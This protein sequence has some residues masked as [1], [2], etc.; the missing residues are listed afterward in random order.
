MTKKNVLLKLLVFCSAICMALCAFTFIPK[1]TLAATDLPSVSTIYM[2]EGAEVRLKSTDGEYKDVTG[3]RFTMLVNKDYY[4]ELTDSKLT[5][6]VDEATVKTEADMKDSAKASTSRFTYNCEKLVTHAAG[7]KAQEAVYSFNA[8]V[9]GLPS[10]NFGTKLIANGCIKVGNSEP[11]FATN[12]Q[13]RSISQV[14]SSALADNIADDEFGTLKSYVDGAVDVSNFKFGNTSITTDLY[15]TA[16]PTVNATIP[17]N[18]TPIWTS[19]DTE[20]A[21]VNQ[22]GEITRGEKLGTTT[23][24]AK[25]GTISRT[26]TVKVGEPNVN[27][28]VNGTHKNYSVNNDTSLLGFASADTLTDFTGETYMGNAATVKPV[29]S[30]SIGYKV[31]NNYTLD[32][33]NRIA[34]DYN[35]VTLYYAVNLTELASGGYLNFLTSK[36]YNSFTENSFFGKA[37]I[38]GTKY[39]SANKVWNKVSISISDYIAIATESEGVAT[40][41][42]VLFGLGNPSNISADSSKIY[43]SDIIFELVVSPEILTVTS[44]NYKT[45]NYNGNTTTTYLNYAAAGSTELSAISGDYEGNA[46]RYKP[47]GAFNGEYRVLN[48]LTQTDFA[49][50]KKVY[51]SVSLWWAFSLTKTADSHYINFLA[52]SGGG[53]S[54]LLTAG[55]SSTRSTTS[56]KHQVWQKATISID[57]YI[58]LLEANNYTHCVLFGLGGPVGIDQSNSAIYI[59]DIFFENV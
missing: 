35:T 8:V 20:V 26:A 21:T 55:I 17:E 50:L 33:L 44:A 57:D 25:L 9:A 59:G 37:G 14:A 5:I 18:L 40:S 54:F 48:T 6:Y 32:E 12:P 52:E 41:S 15:K 36:N 47:V 16:E 24:T 46:A 3:I 39:V 31:K 42:V 2:S 19:S 45:F 49:T 29:S 22:N 23:I 51:N 1:Q 38:Y 43:I 4:D 56:N 53:K 28:V 27:K 58:A 13:T 30:Y 7:E 10:E 11:V 34:E